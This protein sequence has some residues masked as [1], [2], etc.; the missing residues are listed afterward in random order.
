MKKFKRRLS[1]TLT[2]RGRNYDDGLSEL[3]EQITIDDLE[4]HT[5]QQQQQ[6]IQQQQQQLEQQQQQPRLDDEPS[7]NVHNNGQNLSQI[8]GVSL[9]ESDEASNTAVSGVS[10]SLEDTPNQ[11]TATQ[12]REKREKLRQEQ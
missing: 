10:I 2:K 11:H 6:N 3:A 12:Q 8:S 7:Q 5:V 1:L 9:T 4:C